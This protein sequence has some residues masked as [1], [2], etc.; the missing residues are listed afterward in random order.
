MY[1]GFEKWRAVKAA[2]D[3]EWRFSSSLSRRLKMHES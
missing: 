2:V 3:P 1:P